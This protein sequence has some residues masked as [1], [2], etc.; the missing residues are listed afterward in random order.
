MHDNGNNATA[1]TALLAKCRGR[2][3]ASQRPLGRFAEHQRRATKKT[4]SRPIPV[5]GV[6]RDPDKKASLTAAEERE[7]AKA[8][9]QGFAKDR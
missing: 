2:L 7:D 5:R 3:R 6:L 8:G 9:S 1:I 4:D